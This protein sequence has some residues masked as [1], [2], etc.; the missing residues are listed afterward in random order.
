M[1]RATTS[2]MVLQKAAIFVC[3]CTIHSTKSEIYCLSLNEL[4]SSYFQKEKGQK[5]EFIQ[6]KNQ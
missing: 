4:E 3:I 1:T 6:I 2:V 5:E